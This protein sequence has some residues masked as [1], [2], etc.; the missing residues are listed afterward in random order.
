MASFLKRELTSCSNTR[1][2]LG[3]THVRNNP[4]K[5][6]TE[7][8]SLSLQFAGP[9]EIH[10]AVVSML[11]NN[12]LRRPVS[13]DWPLVCLELKDRCPDTEDRQETTDVAAWE[14]PEGVARLSA[15]LR[16]RVERTDRCTRVRPLHPGTLAGLAER[17]PE[18]AEERRT[19]CNAVHPAL[20]QQGPPSTVLSRNRQDRFNED[21][22]D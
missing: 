21:F 19:P 3:L 6:R 22:L 17:S 10:L 18:G 20:P 5:G 4:L 16:F 7:Y 8:D 12:L 15:P 14:I 11:L 2:C 1:A 9:N 13:R